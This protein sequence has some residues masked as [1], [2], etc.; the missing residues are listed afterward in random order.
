MCVCVR[1]RACMCVCMCVQVHECVH[2]CVCR[3]MSICVWKPEVSLISGVVLRSCPTLF[4]ETR[5]LTGL[6]LWIQLSWLPGNPGMCLPSA[7]ITRVC[8]FT[9]L[10][11]LTFSLGGLNS[12]PH[13]YKAGN[14]C[15]LELSPRP[16]GFQAF[17]STI[18][19]SRTWSSAKR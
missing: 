16:V 14:T 11:I 19:K 6:D 2:A 1:A 13:A 15:S 10:S 17:S 12:G 5:S 18:T 9:L 8:L 3:R 4:L 7:R